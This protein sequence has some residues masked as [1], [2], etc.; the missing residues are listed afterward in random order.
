[1]PWFCPYC[2]FK[3]L[4]AG[5]VCQSCKEKYVF[6]YL[7]TTSAS[8]DEKALV[9]LIEEIS[10]LFFPLCVILTF[11]NEDYMIGKMEIISNASKVTNA[12][13]VIQIGYEA[14]KNDS[15]V[16]HY[17]LIRKDIAID[18]GQYAQEPIKD[19]SIPEDIFEEYQ[20]FLKN[21][22]WDR[23]SLGSNFG[24]ACLPMVLLIGVFMLKHDMALEQKAEEIQKSLQL[25]EEE[26]LSQE[27]KDAELAK[28]I[29]EKEKRLLEEEE[30]K[31]AELAANIAHSL[32]IQEYQKFLEQKE[33]DAKLAKVFQEEEDS[34]FAKQLERLDKMGLS[35]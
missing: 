14:P 5:Y 27:K 4:G 15:N 9:R 1:M 11:I 10:S 7:M 35:G 12:S 25:E 13:K 34:N 2:S 23:K 3:N 20:H 28:L 29:Q 6:K 33:E 30:E 16:G 22:E 31:K 17:V 18:L 19:P 21:M 26:K 24:N 32:D 8:A